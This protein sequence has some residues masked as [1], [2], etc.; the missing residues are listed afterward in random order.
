MLIE[1]FPN[2]I[3]PANS[4]KHGLVKEWI[5]VVSVSTVKQNRQP[6]VRNL[7][8]I[9][10][11]PTTNFELFYEQLTDNEKECR[12]FQQDVATCHTSNDLLNRL[13]TS[14]TNE[15]RC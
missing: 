3:I 8:P 7:L 14:F 5:T 9:T 12:F 15:P 6:A 2:A 10:S 11:C 4:S 1:I 13:H